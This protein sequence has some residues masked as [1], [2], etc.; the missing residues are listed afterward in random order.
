MFLKMLEEK[1][2]ELREKKQGQK[3]VSISF[4]KIELQIS[5]WVPDKYFQSET[6]KVQFYREI[7][8][9]TSIEDLNS[10]ISGF[11]EVNEELEK[12]IE[13]LFQILKIKILSTSH[14]ISS[15]KSIG[16]NYQIDFF[17][18]TTLDTLK[19]FLVLDK[20]VKFHVVDVK[21]LRASKKLFENDGKFLQYL[22]DI[23]EQKVWN[24][25]IKLK[26]KK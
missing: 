7:E 24:P 25:K 14:N 21:R 9:L 17:E 11:K 16:V 6:D 15:I 10:M 26:K 3:R 19:E 22:L 23:L 5:A 12:E 4:P 2:E 18:S 1:I 20:E 8:S 13:N